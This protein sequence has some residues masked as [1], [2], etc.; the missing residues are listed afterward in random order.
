MTLSIQA[1]T[2]E[3]TSFSKQFAGLQ[4][5]VDSTSLGEFKT[6][7][8]KY[9]YSIVLGLQPKETSVHLT[10]GLLMHGSVERYHHSRAQGLGHE[11][12]VLGAVHW[13]LK[14][15]W[16]KVLARPSLQGDTY[17]N[18]LT[19]LRT[20]VWYFDQYGAEDSLE[21]IV[22]AN[23]KPAVEL[24]FSFDSG[25]RSQLTGE[26]VL[27]CGYFDRLASLNGEIY[28]PDL[29]TT[30]SEL[31]P[32]FW[33]QFNPNNQFGMYTLAGNVVYQ[34]KVA[35]LIVDGAQV[36]VNSSRFA[37]HLIVM[38]PERIAEWHRDAIW[39]VRLMEGCAEQAYWPMNDKSCSMYGGCP[40][41]SICSRSPNSREPWL[42]AEFKK[43]TWDPLQRRGDI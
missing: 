40:F 43:R 41:Q 26:L 6:C 39:N 27:F 28:I 17:K 37:R 10:F 13:M 7:P 14:E 29:K 32:Y 9:F 38:G 20:L 25:Y 15:T 24:S 4:L 21:T 31:S 36:L 33:A 42:E 3:N 34:Q 8:R 30:K 5:A 23:G 12:A 22:L 2:Q 11:D 18:R 35:G 1:A 16:N 19:L